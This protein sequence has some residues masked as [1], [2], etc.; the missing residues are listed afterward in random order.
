[1][2]GQTKSTA[3]RSTTKLPIHAFR[4][5]QSVTPQD[6]AVHLSLGL[7]LIQE[8]V[9]EEKKKKS[10]QDYDR[11]ILGFRFGDALDLIIRKVPHPS[12][13]KVDTPQND[14]I[15]IK[16]VLVEL[17]HQS[18]L[19]EALHNRTPETLMPILLWM[20]KNLSDPRYTPIII[21][22]AYQILGLQSSMFMLTVELYG[23]DLLEDQNVAFVVEGITRKVERE[24]GKADTS[25]TLIG[26]LDMIAG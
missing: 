19:P 6:E 1:M 4:D 7:K 18:A 15:L 23:A 25:E 10:L 24:I 5:Y 8:Y 22:V 11:A 13:F 20:Q 3:I 14:S 21:D 2:S 16:T 26:L 12:F 17:K 9:F